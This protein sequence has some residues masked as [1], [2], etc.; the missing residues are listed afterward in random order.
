MHSNYYC[1][2]F[3]DNG[4]NEMLDMDLDVEY[5][6]RNISV[7]DVRVHKVNGKERYTYDEKITVSRSDEQCA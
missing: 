5:K 3:K 4:S 6:D 1:A 2:D 7:A